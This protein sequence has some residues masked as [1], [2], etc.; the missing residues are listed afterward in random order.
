MGNEQLSKAGSVIVSIRPWNS[1]SVEYKSSCL[2]DKI[3]LFFLLIA[4]TSHQN[5]FSLKILSP[6]LHF[7]LQSTL[8]YG[9]RAA[10]QGLG[11]LLCLFGHEIHSVS[12]WNPANQRK[13]RRS[14]KTWFA[15]NLRK[16][17]VLLGITTYAACFQR[18]ILL[19]PDRIVPRYF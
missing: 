18:A 9:E 16:L 17:V 12:P 7:I 2:V 15:C 11:R 1:E 8:Q 14:V 13:K 6:R 3:S 4:S 19:H 10:E 5:D